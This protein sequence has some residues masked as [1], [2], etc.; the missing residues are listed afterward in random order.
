M[1]VSKAKDALANAS[2]GGMVFEAEVEAL[3]VKITKLP[4]M[5]NKVMKAFGSDIKLTN[6]KGEK[7]SPIETISVIESSSLNSRIKSKIIDKIMDLL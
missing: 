5:I 6:D 4:E 7:L 1:D 2:I 3:N